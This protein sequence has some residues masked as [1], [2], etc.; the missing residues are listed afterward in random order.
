MFQA[1]YEGRE[2]GT[3]RFHHDTGD[4][5]GIRITRRSAVLK[6]PIPILADTSRDTY[7]RATVRNAPGEAFEGGGFVSTG[8]A[9]G[10]V[11]AVDFD[12]LLVAFLEPLDRRLD[13][14]HAARIAHL[15]GRDVRVETGAVPVARDGLGVERNLGAEFLS[16]AVEK[17][18][19]HPEMVTHWK[20]KVSEWNGNRS[21]DY[22][23]Y[24]R[25]PRMARSGT[26]T[27]LEAP[28]R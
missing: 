24:C 6:V 8:H 27:G 4:L 22:Q 3:Y 23:T 1:W 16:D 20:R 25:Y 13:V 12:V 11:G 26:P 15:L 2:A 10:V 14:L 9:E 17:E 5:V 18:T 28:R 7:A 19:S 21:L